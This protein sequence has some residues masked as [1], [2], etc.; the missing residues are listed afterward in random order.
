MLDLNIIDLLILD[1]L[2]CDYGAKLL[3]LVKDYEELENP[4]FQT[5]AYLTDSNAD[6]S[7]IEKRLEEYPFPIKGRRIVNSHRKE[8]ELRERRYIKNTAKAETKKA[9]PLYEITSDHYLWKRNLLDLDRTSDSSVDE[10][11][12][13]DFLQAYWMF[14]YAKMKNQK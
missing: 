4:F 12:G 6:I 10:F 3:S 2:G 9:L 7:F 1:E 14:E 5:L 11:Y 13:V 8:I